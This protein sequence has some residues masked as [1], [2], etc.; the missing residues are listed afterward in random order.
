MMTSIGKD[1]KKSWKMRERESRAEPDERKMLCMV[2]EREKVFSH[3]ES[4]LVASNKV[5]VTLLYKVLHQLFD[6]LYS[7]YTRELLKP[8][9]S[10]SHERVPKNKYNYRLYEVF[11]LELGGEKGINFIFPDFTSI[12]RKYNVKFV[13]SVLIRLSRRQH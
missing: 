12:R 11:P 8:V 7:V 1:E 2:V 6:L 5:V 10:L 13:R 3:H 9:T 4:V